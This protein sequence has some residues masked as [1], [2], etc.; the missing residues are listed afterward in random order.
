MSDELFEAIRTGDDAAVERI[1]AARP[2][3][4][5]ASDA[6]GLSALTVA[7]YHGRWQLVERIRA[8]GA[9]L[10]LFEA[11]IVG[12]VETVRA[13]LDEAER[14]RT[15]EAEASSRR[16][17]VAPLE[18]AEVESGDD[19]D[20]GAGGTGDR[21]GSAGADPTEPDPVDGRA[22]D[23]FTALHLAAFFGRPS[24]ARLLLDRGAD[25]N[26]RATGP[27]RVQPL[28]SAVA[29]G[30]EAVA[31]MLIEAGAEVNAA[32]DGGYTPLMGAAQNGLAATVALLLAEGADPDA[33]NE[34][35][36]TAADLADRAGHAEIAA[37]LRS[38]G[39]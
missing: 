32:Q 8:A 11:A 34:D 6:A 28:H 16:G 14:E 24:V 19:A 30:H 18:R 25:P 29:G 4:A 9:D 3:A 39:G 27:L 10:D 26:A 35:V 38:A 12:D 33:L 15:V 5:G 31:A 7:A 17:V 1:L 20:D 36:L 13:R 21:A 22:A 23:G 37:S 2:A